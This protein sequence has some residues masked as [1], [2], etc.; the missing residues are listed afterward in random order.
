MNR[1]SFLSFIGL[2]PFFYA[3]KT[4]EEPEEHL[5]PVL[6]EEEKE[7]KN[8]LE[9]IDEAD[10]YL[11]ENHKVFIHLEHTSFSS[12]KT[13]GNFVNLY[14]AGILIVRVDEEEIGAYDHCC[15]HRGTIGAWTYHNKEFR[16]GTHGNYFSLSGDKVVQC[17]SNSTSGSL[18][19]FETQ[20]YKDLL[21]VNLL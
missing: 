18:R 10:G 20:L 19:A 2:F 17:N 15:P 12:L 21:T 11:I 1:K 5:T 3:C 16:C 4:E 8:R 7:Y 6:S 14:E 9:R 13:E